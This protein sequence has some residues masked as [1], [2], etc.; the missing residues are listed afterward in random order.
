MSES[1]RALRAMMTMGAGQALN[2]LIGLVM[3]MWVPR[4][5]GATD[6]GHWIYFRSLIVL[7][8]GFGMLGASDVMT[9]FYLGYRAE[10]NTVDAARVFKSVLFLRCVL[11]CPLAV[12][13]YL[14]LLSSSGAFAHASAG[15]YLS[16]CILF[17]SVAMTFNLLLYGDR[18]LGR[19]A[20][21]SA[22]QAATVPV[23]VLIAYAW[24][25]LAFVPL[26][27]ML[28]DLFCMVVAGL[29]ARPWR[30]WPRGWLP[31]GQMRAVLQLGGLA[32]A[33]S[34]AIN[35]YINLTPYL[36]DVRGYDI[37]A[38]GYIGF[39]TRITLVLFMG[40][41]AIGAGLYPSLASLVA[42]HEMERACAWQSACTRYGVVLLLLVEGVFILV[43][44]WLVPLI[45]GESFAG[46]SAMLAVA[47][48]SVIPMWI[49]GQYLRLS[50]LARRSRAYGYAA[51]GLLAGYLVPL[52]LFE[53]DPL[54][55]RVAWAFV[56]GGLCCQL[57]AMGC[58]R[59]LTGQDV[60]AV[61][62]LICLVLLGVPVAIRSWSTDVPVTVVAALFW[63]AGFSA[64][65]WFAK[66]VTINEISSLAR[67]LRP[68]AGQP[69]QTPPLN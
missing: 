4:L 53:P 30:V 27:C 13:G 22:L 59:G 52:F 28:G 18:K 64:A 63:V 29:V 16:A 66:I 35:L 7:F 17:Q 40:L 12:I 45:L 54:G 60:R 31:G 62:L 5:F 21:I 11:A 26:A 34:L 67:S 19:H 37:Q 33:F 14:L 36:M 44:P 61:K 15:L 20:A 42:A 24:K 57:A 50:L 43:G 48:L 38:I 47:L 10:G 8:V 58:M 49:A 3:A 68:P 65:V 2:V 6:Y 25:D 69:N 41:T 32:A 51:A 23:A 1:P 9:R 56:A 39:A 46:I 55:M